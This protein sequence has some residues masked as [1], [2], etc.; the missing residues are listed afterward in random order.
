MDI[1]LCQLMYMIAVMMHMSR[2]KLNC[3]EVGSLIGK[4]LLTEDDELTVNGLKLLITVSESLE[5]KQNICP[6][7]GNH[8]ECAGC[9]HDP[10][11]Y[12][13]NNCLSQKDAVL[14]E[15]GCVND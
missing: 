2:P 14:C 1:T 6:N 3:V 9:P 8:W 15:G 11:H 7:A 4:G 13:K 12:C 5:R 10:N